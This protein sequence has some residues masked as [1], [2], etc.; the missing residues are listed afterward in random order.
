MAGVGQAP[1]AGNEPQSCR[2]WGLG[3][4]FCQAAPLSSWWEHLIVA[5]AWVPRR[6]HSIAHETPEF[7]SLSSFFLESRRVW[8]RS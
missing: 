5:R 2:C 7:L 4:V 3:C 1:S 6:D 8:G